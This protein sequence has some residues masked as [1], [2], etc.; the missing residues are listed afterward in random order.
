[1][2]SLSI[3]NGITDEEKEHMFHCFSPAAK[4]F[5]DGE[6]IM[7]YAHQMDKI[8]ILLSGRA[9]LSCIDYEGRHSILEQLEKNDIFGEVFTLPLEDF[10][11]FVVA[12]TAC[13]VLFIDYSQ[14]IKR[15]SNACAEHSRLVNNLLQ[16]T[17]SKAQSMALHINIL[18]RRTTRQ[19]LMTY[20]EI[21]ALKAKEKYFTIPMSLSAL[22]DYISVDRSSMM[23]ELR[24][25]K[26]EGI[27]DD[28]ISDGKRYFTLI[29][30]N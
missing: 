9:H 6:T 7:N 25:M 19:K 28:K 23:R 3:F 13:D 12:D 8:G 24:K 16:M 11:Y 2:S 20:F 17:A 29:K 14:I 21:N 5:F 30:N 10:Q 22:A 18:S 26:E 1:M 27:I 4:V 15:C